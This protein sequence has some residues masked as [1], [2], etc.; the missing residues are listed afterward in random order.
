M[1]AYTPAAI[2]VGSHGYFDIIDHLLNTAKSKGI[3]YTLDDSNELNASVLVTAAD[4][5][6]IEVI[7]WKLDLGAPLDA[8]RADAGAFNM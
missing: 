8:I 4:N 7:K 2:E 1:K 5:G 6:E 3:T